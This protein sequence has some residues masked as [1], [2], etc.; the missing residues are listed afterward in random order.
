MHKND[1]FFS[2]RRRTFHLCLLSEKSKNV[3]LKL[4]DEMMGRYANIHFGE[5]FQVEF[6]HPF[7]ITALDL[8]KEKDN[9]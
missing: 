2:L 7:K 4:D 5:I 6:L 8:L 9:Q 3:M 1:A